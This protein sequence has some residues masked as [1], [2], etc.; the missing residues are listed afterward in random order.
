MMNK[1]WVAQKLLLAA[2]S[3][4]ML[5]LAP[6]AWPQDQGLRILS[7]EP[8]LP[9]MPPAYLRVETD[10]PMDLENVAA[11]L[12][13]NGREAASASLG[14]G[15]GGGRR[16]ADYAVAVGEPG[17][18]TITVTLQAGKQRL[19]A[20]KTIEFRSP[21][22]AVFLDYADG[23]AVWQRP[24]VQV[25]VYF[26]HHPVLTVNG[27]TVTFQQVSDPENPGHAVL[28]ITEGWQP[29]LNRL[30][31]KGTNNAG[32]EVVRNLNLFWMKDGKVKQG[33]T[34]SLFLGY[35]GSKSGPFYYLGKTG[36]ALAPG[37]SRWGT[38]FFLEGGHWLRSREKML[39][40]VK[41]QAP[42][43]EVITILVKKHFLGGVEV[44]RKLHLQVLP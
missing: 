26:L 18:K 7:V 19:T 16:F 36:P 21:G 15:F 8:L 24:Q 6:A 2:I 41:A 10:Y 29:G 32:Q 34:F 1:R 20:S 12:A 27:K 43:H 28:T 13:V 22:G 9:G 23:E 39:R 14:G 17:R 5:A 44:D 40:E 37:P 30:E 35:M 42:G 11:S 38:A 31:C 3:L 25:Y 4:I 33:D